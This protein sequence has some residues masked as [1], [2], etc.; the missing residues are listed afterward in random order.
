MRLVLLSFLLCLSS[1][2]AMA[3]AWPRKAGEGFASATARFSWPQ[4]VQQLTSLAPSQ[5]Y[6]TIY[7]EYGLTDRLTLGVDLGRSVSGSGKSVVFLQYPLLERGTGP[8][9]AAQLG[10]G[11][12]SGRQVIRPGLSVGLGLERGWLSV[13]GV[14]EMRLD[15]GIADYKIDMTWG[16]NF[17]NGRKLILQMQTGA[18]AG[19]PVFARFAPSVV[20]PLNDRL[21][22]ETGV[23]YGLTGDRS[24]GVLVGLWTTF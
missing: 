19:D 21:T 6:Y 18:P 17:D 7:V 9:V 4:D 8:R 16:W 1:A 5:E 13:D 24:F 12:I 10:F 22:L 11:Q 2:S 14:A 23:A 20:F 15:S 3:G